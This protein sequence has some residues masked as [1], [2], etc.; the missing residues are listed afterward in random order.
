VQCRSSTFILI[1]GCKNKNKKCIAQQKEQLFFGHSL[2]YSSLFIP[3]RNLFL[4]F[5]YILK[6][7]RAE[8]VIFVKKEVESGKR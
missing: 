5:Y 6:S 1:F 3:Q 4:F 2:L 8:S 7:T